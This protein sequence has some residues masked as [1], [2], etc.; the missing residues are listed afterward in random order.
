MVDKTNKR[1]KIADAEELMR[2]YQHKQ[3]QQHLSLHFFDYYRQKGVIDCTYEEWRSNPALQREL[4]DLHQQR[5]QAVHQQE[6]CATDKELKESQ[7]FQRELNDLVVSIERWKTELQDLKEE[8][9]KCATYKEWSDNREL[10]REL[11]DLISSIERRKMELQNLQKK[12]SNKRQQ[13]AIAQVMQNI[14]K[15]RRRKANERRK[16]IKA[17]KKE[18]KRRAKVAMKEDED[19][20]FERFIIWQRWKKMFRQDPPAL[21]K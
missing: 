5:Q 4:Y 21:K 1:Q 18:A 19:L 10:Q 15:E 11:H 8:E 16:E 6:K 9:E 13:K 17:I 3:Q 7:A 2:Q 14:V 20:L 12:K